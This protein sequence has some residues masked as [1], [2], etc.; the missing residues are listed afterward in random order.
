MRPFLRLSRFDLTVFG[1]IAALVAGIVLTAALGIRQTPQRLAYLKITGGSGRYQVWIADPASPEDA[2][3]VTNANYGVFDYDVSPDGDSIVYSERDFDS[4]I[5][6]LKLLDLHSG[7][8]RQLTNCIM[9]DSDCDAPVFH[10]DGSIIAYQ[11]QSLNTDLGMGVGSIRIWLLD[12]S[13]EPPTTYPLFSEAEIVGYTP[14]WSADGSHI[15]FYDLVNQ[16]ILVFDF[17]ASETEGDQPLKFVPTQM[18][19]VGSL[20]P[21]GSQMIFPEMLLG[22]G[23]S[24]SFLQLADLTN[25]VFET[26][27]DPNEPTD[28]QQTAWSPDGRYIALGRRYWDE[29][30]TIGAQIYLLDMQDR[31]VSPLIVDPGY[32]NSMFVWDA[33]GENLALQRFAQLQPTDPRYGTNTTEVWTYSLESR[34]LVKIDENARNPKWV[35][36]G[37]PR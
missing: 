12:I 28:D 15:A 37:N 1:V 10:P 5:A 11:R 29:R 25:G 6:D 23:Q 13:T 2:E 35:A 19:V 22:G 18:G 33:R 30:Y 32:S 31:S 20:S 27:F 21:D 9:E 17:T 34:R 16:G 26:L 36:G 4:G 3:Q 8:V 7:N 14:I 24:R